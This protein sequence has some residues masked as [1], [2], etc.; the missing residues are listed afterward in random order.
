M[1]S[2]A[3]GDGCGPAQKTARTHAAL[4]SAGRRFHEGQVG[5]A[6][7]TGVTSHLVDAPALTAA[8][9]RRPR[10]DDRRPLR[11]SA[12]GGEVLDGAARH[13]RLTL[14]GGR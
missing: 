9:A 1:P 13:G 6:W 3:F 4:P 8:L 11:R 5:T 12:E 7:P 10:A 2:P 14:A